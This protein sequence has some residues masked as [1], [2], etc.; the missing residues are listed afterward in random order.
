M[1]ALLGK[2]QARQGFG[3]LSSPGKEPERNGKEMDLEQLLL[4]YPHNSEGSEARRA[5][6]QMEDCT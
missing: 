6:H 4:P 1:P 2:M 3:P 5:S